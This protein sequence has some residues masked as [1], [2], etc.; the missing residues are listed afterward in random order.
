M[1]TEILS[2]TPEAL[3]RAAALIRSGDLVAFPTETVYGLGAD[4][5]NPEAVERIFAAKGRPGDNPLIAHIADLAA[6]EPLIRGGIG[7]LPRKLAEAFWPGP[8]TMIFPKS[9]RVPLQVTA[10]LS[11]V[12]VRMPSHPTARALIRAADTPIAAPSANRSGRPSPTTA[13]HVLDDMQGRIPLILDG[14]PCAVGLESTVLDVTGEIPRIL[15]PGGVTREMIEAAVGGCLVDP[16][17]MR[18]L[19]EGEKPRSPGMKYRH[20]APRGSLTIVTGKEEDVARDICRRYDRALTEGAR[21]LILA[22]QGHL[23]QY[24]SRRALS[25]G[26]DPE[27][28]ARRIFDRLREADELGADVLFSEAVED[29]GIGLAVMNRL[30]RAAAFHIVQADLDERGET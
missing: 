20:Y 16:A 18:P 30:G 23:P 19:R 1:Q 22:L 26:E 9:E 7:P 21:P 14:G 3:D 10:G 11:T 27:E 13:Q 8:M 25:L 28:M 24:G 12:A 29:R 6:L 5:L 2:P 17:V 4:A 15:R